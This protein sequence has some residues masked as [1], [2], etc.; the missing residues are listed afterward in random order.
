MRND[1]ADHMVAVLLRQESAALKYDRI[2]FLFR[3]AGLGASPE[4]ATGRGVQTSMETVWTGCLQF[5]INQ[6]RRR[7][8][9][10]TL[11]PGSSVGRA[12]D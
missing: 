7:L 3:Y 4:N 12:A 1:V 6:V 5:P 10:S 11:R 8:P 2:D 9:A